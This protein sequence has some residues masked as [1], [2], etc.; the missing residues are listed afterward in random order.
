MADHAPG[1]GANRSSGA[2]RAAEAPA[3]GTDGKDAVDVRA[4]KRARVEGDGGSPKEAPSASAPQEAARTHRFSEYVFDTSG[5]KRATPDSVGITQFRTATQGF[6][7]RFKDRFEDFVVSEIDI[8]GRVVRLCSEEPI[9][10]PPKAGGGNGQPLV[11]TPE[12]LAAAK[13][14]LNA[15]VGE[16]EASRLV[17]WVKT[18]SSTRSK[19]AKTG[20]S[21]AKEAQ[22]ATPKPLKSFFI[23]NGVSDKN[24]RT[25]IHSIVTNRLRGFDST[26]HGEGAD[27]RIEVKFGRAK[28]RRKRRDRSQKYLHFTLHKRGCDT[29]SCVSQMARA[30]GIRSKKFGYA[31]T[32]DKRAVTTQRVSLLGG[33]DLTLAAAVRKRMS[34]C[35][36]V[37]DF[38]FAPEQLRLG[39]HKGNRFALALRGFTA[40][41]E[42][43]AAAVESL[44]KLGCINYF[45]MQRF[46]TSSI[47]TYEVGAAM[48]RGE[49]K[50]AV[51]LVLLPR[52]E[53]NTK[54]TS[55][56]ETFRDTGDVR[57][58]LARLPRWCHAERALLNGL[59]SVG[60]TAPIE[61]LQRIPRYMRL[62]Y[63]HSF[64]SVVWNK[65]AS[66]R[67]QKF[68]P[69]KPA[70]G[71][72]VFDG[73]PV[74]GG[75]R[76]RGVPPAVK[77]LTQQDVESGQYSIRDIVLPLPGNLIKYPPNLES[78]YKRLQSEARIDFSILKRSMLDAELPGGYRKFLCV[79]G[80]MKWA[81]VEYGADDETI[82]IEPGLNQ[83]PDDGHSKSGGQDGDEAKGD[84][85]DPKDTPRKRALTVSFSLPS[86]SYATIVLRELMKSKV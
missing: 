48:L 75:V 66:I 26:T 56:R 31:G 82:P 52:T 63:L 25:R 42:T 29:M 68:D 70:K 44:S 16:D 47:S 19:E 77:A 78:E 61:A 40:T 5:F 1:A 84:E 38:A 58:S 34:R 73:E 71:D 49:W 4:K 51:G 18:W 76:E 36:K 17:A 12:D 6:S 3:Q 53:G 8:Q 41:D 86:S 20:D 9:S 21:N 54:N 7:A 22:P 74:R 33:S 37:G 57:A 30:L 15:L 85:T 28:K 43:A 24:T 27:R 14:E 46:G 83:F 67:Q 39:D 79:P 2:K 13:Q 35:A 59:S 55:A 10:A 23:S 80:D 50:R 72:L 11:T 81:V 60:P 32:K 69:S 62:M 65:I 64:Q 45:G